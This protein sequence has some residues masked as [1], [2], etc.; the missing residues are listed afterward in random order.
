MKKNKIGTLVP[1]LIILVAFGC[2]GR[3]E[4]NTRPGNDA[5]ASINTDDLDKKFLHEGFITDEIFR[6]VIIAAKEPG[7]IQEI[8]NRARIRARV[9]LE[10]ML[11]AENKNYKSSKAGII[12]LIENN[13]ALY[14]QDLGHRRYEVYYFDIRKTDLRNSLKNIGS[15]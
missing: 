8:Q 5:N 6:V 4:T 10:R 13:G 12:N 2:A 9:S 7:N 3:Q 14:K 15:Q 1:A 11:S